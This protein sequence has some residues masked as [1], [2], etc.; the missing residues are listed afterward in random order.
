MSKQLTDEQILLAEENQKESKIFLQ[1]VEKIENVKKQLL[2]KKANAEK[3]INRLRLEL[4]QLDKEY[5]F[6]TDQEKIRELAAKKKDIRYEIDE[7]ESIK[8]TMYNPV[9]KDMLKGIEQFRDKADKENSKFHSAK[10]QLEKQYKGEWEA[11]NK[12]M[13]DRLDKLDVL[14][15]QHAFTQAYNKYS[16]MK[17]DKAEW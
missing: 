15:Y 4:A 10:A 9:I 1:E 2:D 16:N 14:Y 11:Y 13:Q 3:E 17:M 12:A 6:E 7:Y 5:L 8:D